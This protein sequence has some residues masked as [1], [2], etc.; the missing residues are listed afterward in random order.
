MATFVERVRLLGERLGPIRALV[1]SARDEG[2]ITFV[3]GSLDPSLQIAFDFRHDSWSG[4]EAELPT[5]ATRVG[6]VD[7]AAP[8]RYLRLR[9]PPYDDEALASWADRIRGLLGD[10]IDVYCYF[11]HED[12]PTAPRYAAHL[13]ELVA[14]KRP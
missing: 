11:K 8:F 10:G 14:D 1:G 13:L 7:A 9:E 12:E 4:I 6:D 3:L 5:N 2:L